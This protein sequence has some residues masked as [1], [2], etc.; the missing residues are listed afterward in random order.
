MHRIFLSFFLGMTALLA[1]ADT[2]KTL[3]FPSDFQK[4]EFALAENFPGI[5]YFCTAGGPWKSGTLTL[6]LPEAVQLK[7]ASYL[8]ATRQDK[9]GAW[10][11]VFDPIKSTPVPGGKRYEITLSKNQLQETQ[12]NVV[13]FK[14]NRIFLQALPGNAGKTFP[15]KWIFTADGKTIRS[16]LLRLKIIPPLKM[17]AKGTPFFGTQICEL[18]SSIAA[19][20]AETEQKLTSYWRGLS[21]RPVMAGLNTYL[22]PMRFPGY[23]GTVPL[24]TIRQMPAFRPN[25]FER[26]IR[27]GKMLDRYP[28]TAGKDIHAGQHSV[29]LAY[30]TEDPKGD[31]Q[32]YYE[33]GVQQLKQRNP[34]AKYIFWNYE[35]GV[36]A[37]GPYDLKRFSEHVKAKKELTKA[38]IDR[39]YYREWKNWRFAQ[40]TEVIRRVSL[41]VRKHWPEVKL[42]LCGANVY[43]DS[44]DLRDPHCATDPRAYDAYVDFHLPMSYYQGT[45][46]FDHSSATVKHTKK[47]VQILID[48]AEMYRHFYERYTPKS[49]YQSIIAAAAMGADGIGFY[50]YESYDA[51]HLQA[52]ADGFAAVEPVDEIYRKGEDITASCSVVPAN[53]IQLELAGADGKTEKVTLPELTKNIRF[54]VH[55]LGSRYAVTLL[56]YHDKQEV[57]FRVTVPGFCKDALFFVPA[58]GAAVFETLPDQAAAHTALNRMLSKLKQE[59]NLARAAKDGASTEWRAQDSRIQFA[60]VSGKYG[61][62][63]SLFDPARGALS[64]WRNPSGIDVMRYRNTRGHLGRVS[65]I[66]KGQAVEPTFLPAGSRIENGAPEVSFRTSVAGYQD[67]QAENYPLEGLEITNRFLQ[68]P[69]G[70]RITQF[71]TVKNNSPR[72]TPME[73]AIRVQTYPR[74]GWSMAHAKFPLTQIGSVTVGKYVVNSGRSVSIF[75]KPGTVCPWGL[76]GERKEWDG[77]PVLMTAKLDKRLEEIRIAPDSAFSTVYSWWGD[78]DSYTAEFI[79]GL[80]RL[81]YEETKTFQLTYT[82]IIR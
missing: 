31:F 27:T 44:P 69:D 26:A 61:K 46:F 45:K 24:C 20:D 7:G 76:K 74:L 57:C 12:Q 71:I 49:L 17:P 75:E 6:E 8:W 40:A 1:G 80:F 37:H 73:T 64:A 47:P 42:I 58:N 16:D 48:P 63:V 32:R 55:K 39:D 79:T 62:L 15:V 2:G 82:L 30:L 67:A 59:T 33:E 21:R 9:N 77:S 50:P 43:P 68:S 81:A 78:G 54:R 35:P 60:L 51:R 22:N 11:A 3:L 34:G 29:C 4:G 23:E 28:H 38:E 25:D 41:A 5:L 36:H 66:D 18:F 14:M 10:K 53:S 19:P 13:P 65:F 52:I 72:R 56:N 70:Y